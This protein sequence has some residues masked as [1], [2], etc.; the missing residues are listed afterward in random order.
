[1]PLEINE[2]G[3]RMRVEDGDEDYDGSDGRRRKQT[4]ED[5]D[6]G[7]GSLDRGGIVDDCVRRVLQVLKSTRER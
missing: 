7:C 6:C 5:D 4:E 1:M 2:I 3:I